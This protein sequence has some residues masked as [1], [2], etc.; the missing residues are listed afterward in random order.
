[1]RILQLHSNFIE[2]TPIEKEAKLAEDCE[3]KKQH[4]ED[5]VVLF[6]CVEKGDNKTVAE[7]AIEEVRVA[8]KR[9]KADRI[10]IYPYAHLSNNLAKPAEA[11]NVIKAME[12]SAREA[13]FETYRTPFGWCKEFSILL[14]LN[15][16]Y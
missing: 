13:G 4:L 11:L 8:L 12:K 3:V 10:L 7:K 14:T 9:L 15:D 6:T 2:Y 1:M 16:N 5:L